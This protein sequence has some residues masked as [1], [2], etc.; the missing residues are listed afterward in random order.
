M[1]SIIKDEQQV[2]A[3]G[4][5]EEALAN[6]KAINIVLEHEDMG[7]DYLL[8]FTPEDGG[9]TV[10]V[11]IGSTEVAKIHS[12]LSSQKSRLVKEIKSKAGKYRIELDQSDI[13]CMGE[14]NKK[15]ESN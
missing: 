1:P 9:K 3:L 11:Q 2:K 12:V 10:K 8:A 14:A 4:E 6:I 15:D 7:G 13:E 5:I